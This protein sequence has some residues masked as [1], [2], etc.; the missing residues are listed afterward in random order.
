MPIERLINGLKYTVLVLL[1]TSAETTG[2]EYAV[3]L[4]KVTFTYEGSNSPAIHDINL[5]VKYGEIVAIMGRT[6]AGKSTLIYS[7]GGIIPKYIRGKLTGTIIVDGLDTRKHELYELAL[8]VGVIMDDPEVHITSFTV[9]E[10]VA[11]GPCN[12]GLP[13]EEVYKRVEFALEATRLSKLRT[14]N[15]YNLSGGEKQSLAIA[16]VLSMRPKILALDEPTSMLDPLGRARVYSVLKDLNKRYGLTIIFSCHDMENIIGLVDRIVIMDRGS[17]VLDGPPSYVLQRA[18]IL[19]ECGIRIPEVTKL[20]LLLKKDGLWKTELPI[21]TEDAYHILQEIISSRPLVRGYRKKELKGHVRKQIPVIK[22]RKLTH[23]YPNGVKA[24]MGIELDIYQ[25]EYVALIGQN[26]SGKTTLARCIAGL[27]RPSSKE[28]E[29]LVAGVDV[30]KAKRTD[31]VK[32]IGYVFQIP[33]HQIFHSTV[34]EELEFGPR[35]LNL[36]E[37]EVKE[38]VDRVLKTLDLEKYQDEWPL[39]LDRG[40]RFRVALGSVLAIDPEVIIVDEPTTGQDWNESLYICNLLKKLN[41]EGRTIIIITHEMDLVARFASRVIVMHKGSVLLDGSPK[42]V[43]SRSEILKKTWVKPPEIIRLILRIEEE[44][45]ISTDITTVEDLY[46]YI[47]G[48][49]SWSS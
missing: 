12:L 24:L 9:E 22:V 4:E 47:V 19:E 3:V 41:E 8:H 16:G 15:P 29:I 35:N 18:D 5:K 43:F 27:L 1:M 7:I 20:A 13:K 34:R 31:I 26:G 17:I 39:S 2:C 37:E 32:R 44:I 25:G 48:V 14:R 30:N 10:D 23:T 45:G 46:E 36:P 11:L 33:E 49:R 42:Y 28:A 38:R 21:S 40:K 6:G